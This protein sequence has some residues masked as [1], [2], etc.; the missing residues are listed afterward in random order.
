MET[1]DLR[2]SKNIQYRAESAGKHYKSLQ[3]IWFKRLGAGGREFE[4][5]HSDHVGAKFTLLRR[6]FLCSAK[7]NAIRPL[8]CSS[9][10]NRTRA[11]FDSVFLSESPKCF[12]STPAKPEPAS[13]RGFD[14]APV[15][16]ARR[17][18]YAAPRQAPRLFTQPAARAWSHS[19]LP[20]CS[21]KCK[22][23]RVRAG[24]LGRQG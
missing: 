11:G 1:V 21:V 9:F 22:A 23:L 15:P 17:P 16:T 8:L 6:S 13:V 18:E 5:R 24:A 19:C 12:N 10:P 4:S 3:K 14:G 7:K 20:G 2:A